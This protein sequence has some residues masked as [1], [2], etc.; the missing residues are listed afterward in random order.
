MDTTTTLL[1]SV[2]LAMDCFAVSIVIGLTAKRFVVGDMAR[3]AISFGVFQCLMTIIGWVLSAWS[4]KWIGKYG[5]FVA[6]ALLEFIGVKMM[7]EALSKRGRSS[8]VD[9]SRWATVLWLAIATSLD[10]LAV[11]MSY[12]VLGVE[13]FAPSIVI[14]IGSL[15]FAIVGNAVGVWLGNIF[16][17]KAEVFGGL[18]LVLLGLKIVAE[19]LGY[20]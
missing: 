11:G 20:V 19:H 8:S 3:T 4:V 15:L 5:P 6:F 1:L 7:Y 2:A 18:L 12:G 16:G 9:V 10:A 14:G 13:I 17:H